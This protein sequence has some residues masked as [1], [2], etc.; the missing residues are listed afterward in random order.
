MVQGRG[1]FKE[2]GNPL[3]GTFSTVTVTLYHLIVELYSPT[4]TS[5]KCLVQKPLLVSHKISANQK[6]RPNCTQ[7]IKPE[8][9]Q[10]H[11]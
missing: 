10:I 2:T 11:G 3:N 9:E 6:K 1:A 8:L 4:R 5:I 7:E